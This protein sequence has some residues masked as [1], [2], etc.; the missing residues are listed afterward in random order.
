MQA[1]H[2]RTIKGKLI[3]GISGDFDPAA[4]EARL[5]AAFESLPPA[6]SP[7]PRHDT[8]H[9][10]KQAVYFINK[11]DVNQSN[12]QIVGL[13]TDRHNPDVPALAVM[14]DIL[15]GGFASRL[16]QKIRTEKGLA[17][18]VGGGYAIRL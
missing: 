6:T 13:G 1:W 9:E 17:Y 15:G 2:D 14:N 10:P 16:F 7:P 4:M 12:V 5:R 3:I 18:A 8:F 11:E